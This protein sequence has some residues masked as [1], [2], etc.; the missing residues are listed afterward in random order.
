MTFFKE[1][2]ASLALQATK[3]PMPHWLSM[4][5]RQAHETWSGSCS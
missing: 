5:I 3:R 1:D 2:G 4:L